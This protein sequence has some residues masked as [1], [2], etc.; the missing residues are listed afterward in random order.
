MRHSAWLDGLPGPAPEGIAPVLGPAGARVVAVD[1]PEQ[2][3]EGSLINV[4]KEDPGSVGAGMDQVLRSVA[5]AR[6]L[7]ARHVV[8]R[9]GQLDLFRARERNEEVWAALREAGPGDDVRQQAAR[10][11]EEVE[12]RIDPLLDGLCRTLFQIC[13]AE[14]EL[15]FGIATPESLFA[16]PTFRT[17]PM[18]LDE[19][20]ERNLG[21]WHDAGAAAATEMLGLAPQQ[22]WA[23]E[24]AGRITGVALHDLAGA[25]RNLPPGA[26]EVD[27]RVLRESLPGGAVSVLEIDSRFAAEE[28]RLAASYLEGI[29][30]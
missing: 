5:L 10:I 29:G 20:K 14:P 23:G 27:F 1:A 22:G 17:L 3:A 12:R 21:Y 7:G 28:V 16:A 11:A 30:Y 15:R 8:L 6:T 19:L 4:P 25:E 24:N 2:P 26:G 18:I 9:L 13:R